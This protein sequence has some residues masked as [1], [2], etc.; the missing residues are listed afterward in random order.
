MQNSLVLVIDDDEAVRD[1][2]GFLLS[3][4]QFAVETY[5]SGLQFLRSWSGGPATCILCDIRMPDLGG[6]ELVT[7]LRRR[8]HRV[9]V[10]IMTGHGDISLAAQVTEAGA[11]GLLEKPFSEDSL[12]A[13]LDKIRPR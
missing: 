13:I 1:S 4:N 6:L 9:P 10:V 12:L 11:D 7:E 2:L 8:G 5:S 3:A